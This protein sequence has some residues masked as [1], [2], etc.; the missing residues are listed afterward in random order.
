LLFQ[1]LVVLLL[2]VFSASG[3]HGIGVPIGSRR[4]ISGLG[5]RLYPRDGNQEA[6]ER[7]RGEVVAERQGATSQGLIG[8]GGMGGWM[9]FVRCFA[10]LHVFSW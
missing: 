2:V 8:M 9:C 6:F 4:G 10:V 5:Q 1:P 7:S 3:K